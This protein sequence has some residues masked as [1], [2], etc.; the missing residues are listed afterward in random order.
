MGKEIRKG[1][2]ALGRGPSLPY[3][4]MGRKQG[5]IYSNNLR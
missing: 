2:Y 3:F 4:A 1:K 5:S